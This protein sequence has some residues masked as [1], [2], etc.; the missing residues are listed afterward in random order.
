MWKGRNKDM[1]FNEFQDLAMSTRLESANHLYALMGLV[2][3]VGEV[4]SLIAKGIRDGV[5]DEEAFNDKVKKELG[6]VLWFIAALCDDMNYTMD[7]CAEAVVKKLK[8]RKE[9]GVL[10][11]SGDDR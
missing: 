1:K 5:E 10:G 8:S 2:G 4:Y 9:R 11:G 6:D 3:E 7:E